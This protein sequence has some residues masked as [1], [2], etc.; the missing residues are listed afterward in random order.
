MLKVKKTTVVK[1]KAVVAKEPAPV[2]VDAV[3]V[4]SAD[5]LKKDDTPVVKRTTRA[6]KE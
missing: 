6:S 4:A 1:T 5:D 3:P 2:A